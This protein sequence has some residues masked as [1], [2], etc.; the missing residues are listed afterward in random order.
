[1]NYHFLLA[2]S[3]FPRSE[4]F[5]CAGSVFHPWEVFQHEH[6]YVILLSHSFHGT[7][8][9]V[10]TVH[11]NLSGTGNMTDCCYLA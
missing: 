10:D 9:C 4:H 1:M 2:D 7:G 5:P 6:N 3:S 8:Q 11:Q